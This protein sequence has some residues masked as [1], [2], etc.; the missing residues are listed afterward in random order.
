MAKPIFRIIVDGRDVTDTLKGRIKSISATDKQGMDSDSAS[1]TIDN[2]TAP[3][4]EGPEEGGTLE[5]WLGWEGKGLGKI[6]NYTVDKVTDQFGPDCLVIDAKA[7]DM[8][9]QL[10]EQKRRSW[11]NTTLGAI[12]TQIAHE[13][14]LKAVI[15]PDLGAVDLAHLDQTDESDM[16]LLTRVAQERGALAKF[17]GH[18]LIFATKGQAKELLT[19]AALPLVSVDKSECQPGATLARRKRFHYKSVKAFWYSDDK[20]N[21]QEVTAG[22]GAPAFTLRNHYQDA[23]TARRAADAKLAEFARGSMTMTVA[24]AMGR[25]DIYAEAPISFTG[26]ASQKLAGARFIVTDVGH[27]F[28]SNGFTTRVTAA[29][30]PSAST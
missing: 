4:F 20:A 14:D 5:L 28:G 8:R 10:K 12:V 6:G 13:H 9:T 7:A 29:T 27:S 1:V 24:L 30:D 25:A 19:G 2:A 3:Y 17:A 16:N 18:Q 21:R 11:D 23:D 15:S 26:Y 22:S